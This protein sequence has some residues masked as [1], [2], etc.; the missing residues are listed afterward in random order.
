MAIPREFI[1]DVIARSDLVEV[2]Q[3]YVSLRSRGSEATGLCP[4]HSERTP[5]FHI[6]ID[7]QL[8]HCFGCGEGGGV[9]QFIQKIENLGFVDTIELLAKRL[10]LAVPYG[11]DADREAGLYRRRILNLLKD[12]ARFFHSELKTSELGKQYLEKRRIEWATA[13]RFGL[14]FAEGGYRLINA[15]KKL[16]YSESDL[17]AGGLRQNGR[18]KFFNRLIFPVIDRKG[19]VIGFGGRVMGDGMPKYLNSPEIPNIYSKRRALYGINL[20]KNTKRPNL[21]L[22][23]GNIDV[24]TLH[25]AGFDNAVASMGTALTT[26]QCYLLSQYTKEL[27]ICYDNDD[28][29]KKATGRALELLRNSPMSVR[30]VTLEG[31]KDVDELISGKG[32]RAF[33]RLLENRAGGTEFRLEQLRAKYDI[34]QNEQKLSFVKD[35]VQL[36]A[37]IPGNVEREIYAASAADYCGIALDGLLGDIAKARKSFV[38]TEKRKISQELPVYSNK[39]YSPSEAGIIRICLKDS[40]LLKSA[41][42]AEELAAL[43]FT[44]NRLQRIFEALREAAD[45][46]ALQ[47][48]LDSEA[49]SLYSEINSKVVNLSDSSGV[50]RDCLKTLQLERAG[51]S[52]DLNALV[53]MRRFED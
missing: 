40:Q 4:F 31:A 44:D 18:D 3:T 22:C 32:A 5:S 30:V 45:E 26:E 6:S 29:G 21:I 48:V 37:S 2:A 25:Q 34:S 23:E 35:A 1:D 49:M 24:I 20:A 19:D 28:A 36:L 14:G 52:G 53:A 43:E 10:G 27:V 7:K 47:S 33:E 46:R 11:D 38:R 42:F 41:E 51:K 9:V 12:A 15:M 39:G 13:V 17:D 16:G 8:Y 50:L